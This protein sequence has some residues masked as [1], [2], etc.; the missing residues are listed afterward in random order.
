MNVFLVFAMVL[1]AGVLFNAP[2]SA[3][4]QQPGFPGQLG[5]P[6]QDNSLVETG[7]N[8]V[9]NITSLES[10]KPGPQDAGSSIKWTAKAVDSDNDPISYMF[11]LKGPSTGDVW[12]SVTKWTLENTWKWDTAPGDA[13]KY[14]I[15]VWVRDPAHAGTEFKPVEKIVDYT[16]TQPQASTGITPTAPVTNAEQN[17]PQAIQVPEQTAPPVETIAVNQPPTVD[18]LTSSPASPQAAGAAVSFTT[19]A[20][21][22]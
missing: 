7:L 6:S 1:I 17:V 8:Q 21:D 12:L 18:G 19:V 15:S 20:S 13:G 22:T 2:T 4:D 14:Q 3:Q 9:P 11:R 16:I 5:L 10:D